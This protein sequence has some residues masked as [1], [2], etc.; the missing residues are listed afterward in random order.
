MKAARYFPLAF[1]ANVMVLFL[2]VARTVQM[3]R[4]K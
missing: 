3:Y 2:T 1:L 4:D